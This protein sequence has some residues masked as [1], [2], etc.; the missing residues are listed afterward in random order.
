MRYSFLKKNK[1]S[2]KIRC[3]NVPQVGKSNQFGPPIC[4]QSA[5]SVANHVHLND[6]SRIRDEHLDPNTNCK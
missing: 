2:F 5:A 3:E 4:C 1:C 6:F